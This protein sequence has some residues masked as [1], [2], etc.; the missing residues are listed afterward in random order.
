MIKEKRSITLTNTIAETLR[1]EINYGIIKPREQLVER[2]LA[3]RFNASNIP[4]REALR[5]LEGEGYIVH[6]KFSGYTSR[7]LN[8]EEMV[9][10]YDLM[11]FLSGQLL[12]RAIPRYNEITF[13]RFH[14]LKNSIEKTN[15]PRQLVSY[16]LGFA[17]V[18]FEPAGMNYTYD[19]AIQLLRRNIPVFIRLVETMF[20][21]NF[22]TTFHTQYIELCRQKETEK[23][24]KIYMERLEFMIKNLVRIINQMKEEEGMGKKK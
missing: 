3:E 23:A 8:P 20:K 22:P 6:K 24:V 17:E 2:D 11:Y 15:E 5:I 14:R 12:P 21:D 18:A 1:N 16:M 13:Q 7:D 19:L 9:E 4:V 10:L